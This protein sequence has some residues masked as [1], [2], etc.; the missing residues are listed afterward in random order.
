MK[1]SAFLLGLSAA[2]ALAA[3]GDA[4]KEV[5]ASV[6]AFNKAAAE[7]DAAALGKLLS[8]DLVYVHSNALTEDKA[9]CIAALVKGKPKFT[10]TEQTIKIYDKTA[11]VRTKAKAVSATGTTPLQ[12]IQV[13]VKSGKSWQL[14]SRHT[15]RL[16]T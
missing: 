1:R 5:A 13:W 16:T 3:A 15:V 9:K 8:D 14:V 11:L 12:M 7:G 2:A 6:E 10:H 4:E